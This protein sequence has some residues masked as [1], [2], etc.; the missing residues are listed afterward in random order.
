L[1]AITARISTAWTAAGQAQ[2]IA[3]EAPGSGNGLIQERLAET[4][5]AFTGSMTFV[6]LHLL[7]SSYGSACTQAG[8]R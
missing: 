8:C 7:R 6:Y 1:T 4:I 3:R 5:T 2:P